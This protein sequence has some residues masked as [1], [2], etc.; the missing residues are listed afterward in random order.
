M[1]VLLA[2]GGTGGHLCPGLA[3]ARE[4]RELAPE[5]QIQFL[6]TRAGLEQRLVPPAGF[7]LELLSAGR[8]SPLSWR[9][10]LNAPRF[11]LALLQSW[12]V[13]R[14]GDVDVLVGLG[15][16]AAA[17]PG[18]IAAMRRVPLVLLEQ[19]TVPGRVTRLLARWATEVHLQF[20]QAGL[21]LGSA[22]SLLASGSPVRPE[23]LRL[24][25]CPP[26]R[27]ESLLVLGGSQGSRDMNTLILEAAPRIAGETGCR[28]IHIAGADNESR[29]REAY[30]AKGVA[31]TVHGFTDCMAEC[32]RGA[33]VAVSRAGAMSAAELAL[34]GVPTI[35][36]P[37]PWAKDDHQ[38]KN[39]E[40]LSGQGAAIVLEQG[41]LTP[42]RLADVIIDLWQDATRWQTMSIAMRNTAKPGAAKIIAGRITDLA[43]QPRVTRRGL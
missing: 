30:A 2:G 19:N 27:G 20:E 40:A 31:A 7:E 8:G 5:V 1:R 41:G 43:G 38:Q 22:K 13:M 32:L 18:L 34:A 35:F 42:G 4:L 33:R 16:Y 17:A 6:G 14:G 9:R 28:V 21:E 23:I 3:L 25:D 10:P 29:V 37:L 39:A 11:L 12:R 24:W 15:G 26:A 36:V